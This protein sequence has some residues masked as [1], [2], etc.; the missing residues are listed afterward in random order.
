MRFRLQDKTIGALNFYSHKRDAL[1]SGQLEEGYM[2][3]MQAAATVANA[4]ALVERGE[5]VAQLHAGLETRVLIG[6]ATGL[7]MAQE[8]I[9]SE[10]AFH[11]LATA[12]QNSNQRLRDIAQRLVNE[13]EASRKSPS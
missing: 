4:K 1:R 8:G 3:A 6:Q 5:E 9:S 10:E 7:M 11:K 12:S 2:F 13:W